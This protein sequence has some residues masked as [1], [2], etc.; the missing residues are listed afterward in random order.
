MEKR[1]KKAKQKCPN[2]TQKLKEKHTYINK[3]MGRQVFCKFVFE[4][5]SIYFN[6]QVLNEFINII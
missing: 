2:I 4:T 1:K 6:R 5:S 3:C